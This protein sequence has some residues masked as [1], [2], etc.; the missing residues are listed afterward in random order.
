V[1][2][3]EVDRLQCTGEGRSWAFGVSFVCGGQQ[4]D[5]VGNRGY[6]LG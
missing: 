2:L 3:L 1:K 5:C 4:S 6:R